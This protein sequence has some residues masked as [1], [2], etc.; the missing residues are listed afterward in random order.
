MDS[1]E[2]RGYVLPAIQ[3]EFVWEPEQVCNL[4]DSVMQGYPFGEFMFWRVDAE[5][6]GQYRWYDFVQKYHQRDNPH[7]PELGPIY[8]KPLTAVL[9][10]QQRLTAFNIGL[11]GSMAVK[12]PYKWWNSSDAFPERVL[13]LDLLAPPDPDEEGS[14]YVFEFID[15]GRIGLTGAHLWFKASDVLSFSSDSPAPDMLDWITDQGLDADRQRMAFRT[16]NRLHQAIC[17]EPVVAYYE[18]K[19]QDIER[20][21]NIF[22]RCNSGGTPLSYSN[23]LLSIATSQ[24][25]TLD[26]RSEVYGLVDDMN[27][28]RAGLLFNADFVL[29]AGLMLTDIASVGFKVENFTHENM[30]VLEK[31]WPDIRQALLETVELVDSF[32][33]D[34]RTIRATNS[35]LPIAYYLYK[36]GAPRDFETSDRFLSDRNVIRG[37]LTR[38]ILKESG[39]WGSGLDTLLTALREVL[40][41]S[42]GSEFPAAK[43]RRL[44]AQRGKTLDFVEE[45]IEDLADMRLGDRRIFPLL[46]MLFPRLESRDGSDIDH[47][48][49][50]SR[51]TPNRLRSAGIG[52]EQIEP[53]RDRC[54]RLANLQLLDRS[55]NNEKRASLPADWLDVHCTDDQD[56]KNYC[57]RHLLGNVPREIEKFT[58]FYS[59]RRQKLRDRIA[60]LVNAV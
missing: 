10:G 31:N 43:L 13:A 15:E 45:E 18:E 17:V 44:M 4:F 22:I 1:I 25:D 14:R 29:K 48:F 9:D 57:E 52:E 47:V 16:L 34:S 5:N 35:L 55:V 12:L 30:A 49:P 6:S 3:R 39:I 26:A 38:S 27:K 36:K 53:F 41:N 20:V 46:T 54:D 37:W 19:S 40:R 2:S 24:W 60:A 56:R 23:L 42:G 32:G 58:D 8:D 51:F 33:F 21:L 11:R 50:K 59:V 7:C 28:V